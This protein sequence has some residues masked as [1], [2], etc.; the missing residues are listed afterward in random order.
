VVCRSHYAYTLLYGSIVASADS[1]IGRVLVARNLPDY[2]VHAHTQTHTQ[3]HTH[4]HT[5]THTYT[6]YAFDEA[7]VHFGRCAH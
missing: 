6:V 4:T 3:T 5:H 2:E 7:P 1:D